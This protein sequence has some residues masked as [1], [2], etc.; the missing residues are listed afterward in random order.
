MHFKDYK[1]IFLRY[2]VVVMHSISIYSPILFY[3]CILLFVF[4]IIIRTYYVIRNTH[5]VLLYYVVIFFRRNSA[6][7]AWLM[8]ALPFAIIAGHCVYKTDS[9]PYMISTILSFGL[10]I[11]SV[12][13]ALHCKRFPAKPLSYIIATAVVAQLFTLYTDLGK[14]I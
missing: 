4:I 7:G 8:F 9:E 13:N 12:S 1:Y 6:P 3:L 5:F 2:L 14:S 11:S 10:L